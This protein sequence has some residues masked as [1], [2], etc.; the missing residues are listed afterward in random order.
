MKNKIKEK[1]NI[2]EPGFVKNIIY[3][4]KTN[5]KLWMII[6]ISSIVFFVL[7][8]FFIYKIL[9]SISSSGIPET[10]QESMAE[11]KSRPEEEKDEC[12]GCIRRSIDG[13][14]VKPENAN[15]P[16]AAV[17]IDNHPDARPPRG[18][19]KASLVYEAEVEGNFTRYMAIFPLDRKIGQI[20]P[21]RSARP[22]F[23][24]W[25]LGFDAL[26]CHC[27]G[28]PQALAKIASSDLKDLNEFYNSSC[29]WRGDDAPAPHNIFTS[30]E[31]LRQCG[32]DKQDR[33]PK[34]E[35][36]EKGWDHKKEEPM[37]IPPY[38]SI[39]IRYG[40]EKMNVKWN[41]DTSDNS[42]LRYLG[43]EKHLTKA[44]E[45]IRAKNILIQY[46]PAKVI[47]DKL[48]LKMNT[49]GWGKAVICH[50][51]S[52]TN[53]QW[54]K[55]GPKSRT[56]FFYEDGTKASL[57]PGTSWVEVVRPDKKVIF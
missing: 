43:D 29:Y 10:D 52:C 56:H 47:D 54:A 17:M 33:V 8:S 48:R 20:G 27:G 7:A 15:P 42:Y 16:L 9:T 46:I 32:Q 41:Y 14:L 1:L 38:P 28:S 4:L 45:E 6:M 40:S 25:A 13:V 35:T 5:K 37:V 51:G 53:G 24:E 2:I 55:S 57:N 18:L 23:V 39:E 26:Y 36:A 12:P 11:N 19:D 34:K 50:D 30:I 22:Y 3:N 44:G 49:D 21:V 31:K